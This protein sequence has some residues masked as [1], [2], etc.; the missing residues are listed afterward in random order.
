MSIRLLHI[1]DSHLYSDPTALLKGLCTHQSYRAVLADAW[2]KFP[3]ID[4]LILGGDMAQDEQPVTYSSVARLLPEWQAPVMITPGN[5]AS[6]TALNNTLIPALQARSSYTDQWQYK[7]W[8]VIALNSHQAGHIAGRLPD[9]AL[10][11]L[12]TD[13]SA[14]TASHILLALHHHP[15]PVGSRWLDRIGLE[16]RAALWAVIDRFPNVRA[17]ICGHIHQAFDAM[18]GTVRV[19]GTPSTAVQF[20]PACEQFTLDSLSPGYRWL[21]LMEDGSIRTGIN[22]ISGFLPPDLNNTTPY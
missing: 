20:A 18:H 19:L 17:I 21:E 4:C 1:S 10:Q 14:S 7:S 13:L 2:Q 5:H 16:N 12:Q 3:D 9:K 8:Q 22:R 6:M 15:I 11:Q